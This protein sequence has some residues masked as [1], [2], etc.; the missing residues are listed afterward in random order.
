LTLVS[1]VMRSEWMP[2]L[3]PVAEDLLAKLSPID[4]GLYLRQRRLEAL[5]LAE[6]PTLVSRAV[7]RLRRERGRLPGGRGTRP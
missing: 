4:R 1:Y 2:G 7:D 3:R 5:G 6:P